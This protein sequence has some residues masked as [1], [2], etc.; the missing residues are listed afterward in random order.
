MTII[1][2]IGMFIVHEVAHLAMRWN[3]LP[4]QNTPSA[5][6]R[7]A[8]YYIE[9]AL[10]QGSVNVIVNYNNSEIWN[11]NSEVKCRLI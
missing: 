8:G 5:F 4:K 6:C 3:L 7:E 10:F 2:A 11:E 9:R 1:V